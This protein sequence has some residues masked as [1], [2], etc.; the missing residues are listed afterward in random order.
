MLNPGANKTYIQLL[1]GESHS[2][3]HTGPKN[4][5]EEEMQLSKWWLSKMHN[6]SLIL[7]NWSVW[8]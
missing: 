1:A 2:D 3:V 7:T 8:L 6:E 5:D 4:C